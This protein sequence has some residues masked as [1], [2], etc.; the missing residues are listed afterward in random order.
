[1]SIEHHNQIA[2]IEVNNFNPVS[3]AATP[4]DLPPGGGLPLDAGQGSHD[5]ITELRHPLELPP[6]LHPVKDVQ[7]TYGAGIPYG[8]QQKDPAQSEHTV[9]SRKTSAGLEPAKLY[10]E[11]GNGRPNN[12]ATMTTPAPGLNAPAD[13]AQTPDPLAPSYPENVGGQRNPTSASGK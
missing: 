13:F 8:S 4:V 6:G 10:D 7:P 11:R 9:N 1:V 2:P 5:E 12:P 3:G